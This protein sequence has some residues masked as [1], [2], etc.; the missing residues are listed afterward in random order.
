[1]VGCQ[2]NLTFAEQKRVF[3][4]IPGFEHAEFARYG[5]M[6]RN[7]FLN[8]PQLLDRN[9]RLKNAPT[10]N[11]PIFIAG[12]LSGTEGYAEAMMSGLVAALAVYAMLT[13]K[14]LPHV[15]VESS[16]GALLAY[17]SDPATKNYQP[18]HVN[19][20]LIPPLEEPIKDKQRRYLA[21][22]ERGE[23][24][25]KNYVSQLADLGLMAKGVGL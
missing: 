11:T 22:A 19:F 13:E 2:T 9:L 3:S 10:S 12:Q 5:V 7:T 6:H 23:N 15:P 8:A 14:E 18:M 20:G 17:A 25:M 21:F 24:A 4:M 16:F 1:L